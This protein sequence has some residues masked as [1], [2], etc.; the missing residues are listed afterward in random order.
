MDQADWL[1]GWFQISPQNTMLSASN[2]MT[3]EKAHKADSHVMFLKKDNK[4]DVTLPTTEQY[5][6]WNTLS[7]LPRS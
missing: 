3:M 1:I 5:Y 2:N 4:T 6:H 7:V